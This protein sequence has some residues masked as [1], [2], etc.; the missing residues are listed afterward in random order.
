MRGKLSGG[1]PATS[2][3]PGTNA[4][5]VRGTGAGSGGPN[6]PIGG[7]ALVAAE[8]L[9]TVPLVV[10]S[11]PQAPRLTKSA[12]GQATRS[13]L[14]ALVFLTER[15]LLHL[16]LQA[17]ARDLEQARRVGDVAVGLF[18]RLLD[19]VAFEAAHRGLDLL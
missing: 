7:G 6:E 2:A 13:R 9:P 4:M 18:E 3:P 15:K 10:R 16:E 14:A 11:W 17:L 12:K 1:V 19:Q 5:P 8:T